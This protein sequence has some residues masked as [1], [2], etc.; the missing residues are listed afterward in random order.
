ML[1]HFLLDCHVYL[2][3]DLNLVLHMLLHLLVI[4]E[5]H[6]LTLLCHHHTLL[7]R[8]K[9]ISRH[10]LRIFQVGQPL[11]QNA[12]IR[13]S[14]TAVVLLE[15]QEKLF[16]DCV[17]KHGV[18]IQVEGADRYPESLAV[19]K[20]A[21]PVPQVVCSPLVLEAHVLI[22]LLPPLPSLCN[23]LH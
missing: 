11:Q 8:R 15:P 2:L 1:L 21:E 5:L 4:H 13:A 23:Q 12:N 14:R 9:E 18:D 3:L 17:N 16:P 7:L 20:A 6:F 19:L 10:D 22:L